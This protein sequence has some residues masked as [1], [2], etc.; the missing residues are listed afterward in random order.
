MLTRRRV[1]QASAA[2]TVLAAVPARPLLAQATSG[3]PGQILGPFYPMKRTMN[4]TGDL[5]RIPGKGGR[6]EG[7][8]LD[9]T[10]TVRNGA[11]EPLRGVRIE[12]WQANSAGR[13]AHPSDRN[14]APLDPNFE[15]YGV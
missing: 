9:V 5:T 12:L 8:I 1:F 11:G 15:G 6:A 2:A 7:L 3:T 4:D 14:P 10:G 13:Y